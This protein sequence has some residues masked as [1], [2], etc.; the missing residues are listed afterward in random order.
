MIK[1]F[2]TL[3]VGVV[4]TLTASSLFA[5]SDKS[6]DELNQFFQLLEQHDKAMLSV[7]IDVDEETIYEK[8]IGFASVEELIPISSDTLFRIGSIS[9]T[10]T[11][12]MIFQLIESED[13][14][15][16]T[17]LSMF[18]PEIPNAE[19]I[20]IEQMLGH[21]SGIHSFT[22]DPDYRSYETK[23]T[24]L[25]EII[26]RI[27]G[28]TPDFSP[29]EETQYSNSNFY[30]LGHIIE[31]TTNS[32][33]QEQLEAR[34]TE[35][36]GLSNTYYGDKIGTREHE[37][38]SY[39]H[40]DNQ[41][42]RSSETHMSVPHGA[43]AIVSNNHDLSKFIRALFNGKLVSTSSLEQMKNGD[44]LGLGLGLN[45]MPFGKTICFGH[46]GGIDGFRS[47]LTYIPDENL[48]VSATVNGLAFD[49]NQI[50]LNLLSSY[51]GKNITLPDFD[52]EPIAIAASKLEQY[53][54]QFKSDTFPLDIAL[55]VR[56]GDL[57]AQATGQGAFPL[58]PFSESE[59]RFDGAGI[60]ITFPEQDAGEID[61]GSFTITQRGN[62]NI[63]KRQDSI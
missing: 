17:P 22:D 7:L 34:I 54:G 56:D 26:A 44:Q 38:H 2:T 19:S 57:F 46:N 16:Q 6:F 25:D 55:F 60:I 31:K 33:Y 59:F 50:T 63:F 18:W 3:L 47:T 30:L 61:H 39:Q 41:W 4:S 5:E 42:T 12:V 27:S 20:S 32:S 58:T 13:L 23:E 10:F 40:R 14:N 21:R 28:Y 51:Y 48:A 36:L 9:K 43:G 49:L 53:T 15:L 52:R 37:A 24:S 62:V 45:K 29:G 1:R 35:P 8:H 11:A